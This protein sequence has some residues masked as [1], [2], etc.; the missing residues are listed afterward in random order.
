[1]EADI[2]EA[3]EANVPEEDGRYHVVVTFQP[4]EGRPHEEQ[5]LIEALHDGPKPISWVTARLTKDGICKSEAAKTARRMID[6]GHIVL[7]EKMEL[8]LPGE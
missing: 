6:R 3:L 5:A 8:E 2:C 7:N 4:S 1:M